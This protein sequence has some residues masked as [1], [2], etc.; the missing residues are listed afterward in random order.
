[1]AMLARW[2]F[3]E[4]MD[5]GAVGWNL[6]PSNGDYHDERQQGQASKSNFRSMQ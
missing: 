3:F 1:M 6:C 5:L 4:C 2:K